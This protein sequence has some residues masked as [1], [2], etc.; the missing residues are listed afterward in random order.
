MHVAVRGQ[1]VEVAFLLYL[2][3]GI[4]LRLSGL[5]ANLY[6]LS[7]LDSPHACSIADIPLSRY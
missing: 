1:L 5:V 7:H 3:L 4:K 2:T 6:P